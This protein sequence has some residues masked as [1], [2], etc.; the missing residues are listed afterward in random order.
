MTMTAVIAVDA[1]SRD[2]SPFTGTRVSVKGTDRQEHERALIPGLRVVYSMQSSFLINVN[3]MNHRTTTVRPVR[4]PPLVHRLAV[5]LGFP[6]PTAWPFFQTT[7]CLLSQRAYSFRGV[8]S[9]LPARGLARVKASTESPK[10]FLLYSPCSH[11]Y[12]HR[13]PAGSTD[14]GLPALVNARRKLTPLP[15]RQS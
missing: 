12:P 11:P 8:A 15:H 10:R 4:E 13:L 7:G 6:S 9:G 1:L 5:G 3:D 2:P 14:L